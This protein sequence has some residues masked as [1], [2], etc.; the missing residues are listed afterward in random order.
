M[1]TSALMRLASI[2]KQNETAVSY[3][4][5]MLLRSYIFQMKFRG[6]DNSFPKPICDV[7]FFFEKELRFM[8]CDK[9][10]TYGKIFQLF[11]S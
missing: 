2:T 8:T 11:L 7:H 9:S 5:S 1:T 4:L 10:R 6:N 3:V